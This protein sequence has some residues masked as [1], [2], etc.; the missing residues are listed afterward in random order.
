M[1]KFILLPIVFLFS[2]IRIIR[3]QLKCYDCFYNE[4]FPYMRD[5]RC[6]AFNKNDPPPVVQC[7][8]GELCLKRYESVLDF[9]QLTKNDGLM[10]DR[11]IE[12]KCSKSCWHVNWKVGAATRCCSTNLCNSSP[13][14]TGNS[15]KNNIL[16]FSVF[17]LILNF[18]N[19]FLH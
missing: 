12:R 10:R 1:R 15:V 2:Q 5:E 3:S 4:N 6:R 8:K 9:H 11:V 14:L 19:R 17:S 7:D 16:F 13:S 18:L